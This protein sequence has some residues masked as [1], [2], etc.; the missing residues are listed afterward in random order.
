MDRFALILLC[1][2]ELVSGNET[3][4][5]DCSRGG[6]QDRIFYRTFWEKIA[7]KWSSLITNRFDQ[8]AWNIT[9]GFPEFHRTNPETALKTETSEPDMSFYR[10]MNGREMIFIWIVILNLHK[11]NAELHSK[12][13][14][15]FGGQKKD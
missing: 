6:D 13:R 5:T 9:L 14:Y 10:V 2:L 11:L 15:C 7:G 8:I 3:K 4:V 12:Q 1:W